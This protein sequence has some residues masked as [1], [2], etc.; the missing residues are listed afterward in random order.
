MWSVERKG[1]MVFRPESFVKREHLCYNDVCNTQ[2]RSA[3]ASQ[4][5]EPL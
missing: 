1:E 5:K 4:R 3:G 2:L